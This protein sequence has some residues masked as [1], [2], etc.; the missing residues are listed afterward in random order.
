MGREVDRFTEPGRRRGRV[1]SRSTRQRT[2]W[3]RILMVL[4][5]GWLGNKAWIQGFSFC[6]P[7][8][9]FPGQADH[10]EESSTGKVCLLHHCPY[11]GQSGGL[12]CWSHRPRWNYGNLDQKRLWR[13]EDL[14]VSGTLRMGLPVLH[15]QQPH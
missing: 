12:A 1:S 6:C 2:G 15:Q 8:R 7:C 14:T 11:Q 10:R 3:K 5:K 13:D 4:V 9:H